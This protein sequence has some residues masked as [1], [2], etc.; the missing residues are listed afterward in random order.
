MSPPSQE[1]LQAALLGPR[2]GGVNEAR[3][4][5]FLMNEAV[6]KAGLASARQTKTGD[7][8]KAREFLSTL[9]SPPS[10]SSSSIPSLSSA[11]EYDGNSLPGGSRSET[12]GNDEPT[13]SSPGDLE[14]KKGDVVATSDGRPDGGMASVVKP[15]RGCASG[16]VFLC[17]GEGEARDAFYKILG[18]PK[19][20]TPGALNDE[21]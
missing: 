9:L 11:P 18:T 5:K 7:W 12:V 1:R 4:D 13:T 10:P 6:R 14:G 2:F 8:S 15:A 21:V 19:Y 3:R 17:R 16:S 20:G